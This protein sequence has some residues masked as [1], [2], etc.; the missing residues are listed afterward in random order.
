MTVLTTHTR[1]WICYL[2]QCR[3]LCC[4]AKLLALTMEKIMHFCTT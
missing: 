2:K 4:L 3:R 1:Y